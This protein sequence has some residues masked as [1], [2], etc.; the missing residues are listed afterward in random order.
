MKREKP[1]Q[2]KSVKKPIEISRGINEKVLLPIILLIV[3]VA[4]SNSLHN[5]ILNFDDV[6]YFSNYPEILKLSWTNITTYFSKH[7]VLMYQP[8]PIL[9][10]AMNEAYSGM[11]TFPMHL[12]N[13]LFHLGNIILI[14]RFIFLLRNNKGEALIVALIFGL[15]PMN[16]EAV[17]W[18]S[19]RSSG[20][21]V[22]FFLLGL[23]NYLL[24][25]K[26]QFTV[27]HL[28]LAGLF[29]LISLFSKAQA[30]TFPLVL[31]LIDYL[32]DRKLLS[33]KVILE[34]I[35]F[36]LLSIVF[37]IVAISDKSTMQNLTEGMLI[38]Y[39][40]A[41]MIF[42]ASWSF[43][44][45]LF[46]FLMPVN[47]CSVYV[48]P[49]KTDGMLPITYYLSLLVIA[50]LIYLIYRNRKDK[51]LLFC[52]GFFIAVISINIQLIPSRL[53]IVTERYGYLPYVGL[54]LMLIVLMERWRANNFAAFQK[55]SS[56]LWIAG[57]LYLVFFSFSVYSRNKVWE[58]DL[59]L[60]N[61]IIS[62][63]A[64]VPYIYRA[65][66]IRGLYE[67][68]NGMPQEGINDFTK[69]IAIY[70]TDGKTYINRAL[71]YSR[72]NNNAA[73][74]SD[75]DSAAILSPTHPEVFSYRS[76]LLYQMNNA[77][78]AWKDC[79]KCIEIDS[80]FVDCYITRGTIAFS[81]QDYNRSI[82]DFTKAV[83]LQPTSNVAYKNRG[84]VYLQL[85]DKVNAC[86][87]FQKAADMGN[88]D[89]YQLQQ[90]NC[91]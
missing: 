55:N 26:K 17:S 32:H 50:G 58:N 2:G 87:D 30:V 54:M 68:N 9:T 49:P 77:D 31:V 76:I 38:N 24:Y 15:H 52:A 16:V 22:F 21:Y 74:V 89:A 8:L 61:D 27:Q 69:A 43:V 4:Y 75:L 36:F 35:P 23:N 90:I 66:G 71:A 67:I 45:Y 19:A 39:N 6:E 47:L 53:F 29:F 18:I 85:N 10:F 3:T 40:S 37:G 28:L 14:Y 11:N 59:S 65:Y 1:Q 48:Y 70:P 51:W 33:R 20:M 60:M 64:E 81:R 34:K 25:I 91:K 56:V 41:D 72:M 86:A 82:A 12:L 13:L 84:Q 73:A 44:F 83:A 42:L 57:A 62:K 79:N 88:A 80:G 5:G 63:N 46:K 7:Y 78:Q